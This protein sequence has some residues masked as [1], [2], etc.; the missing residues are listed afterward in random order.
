MTAE[1]SQA[2]RDPQMDAALLAL[3]TIIN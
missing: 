2:G 3:G 1:D